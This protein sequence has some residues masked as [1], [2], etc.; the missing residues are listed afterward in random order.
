MGLDVAIAGMLVSLKFHVQE[1]YFSQI[2]LLIKQT[3]FRNQLG[4]Y[5][6]TLCLLGSLILYG[7]L[8]E[9]YGRL[10]DL[11]QVI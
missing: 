1:G 9:Q 2:S 6:C 5:V 10:S 11:G 8:H 7:I 4:V 3:R